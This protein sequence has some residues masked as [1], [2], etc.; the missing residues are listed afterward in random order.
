MLT[1]AIF[2]ELG[3]PKT[4]LTPLVYIYRLDTDALVVNGAAMTEVGN[5]QYKY[6]FA[7]W[8]RSIDY[9]VICDS[10][11]LTGSER[12]AYSS[13][14][15]DQ[16]QTELERITADV[17][18]EAKQDIIDTVVDG[19]QTD[20]DNPVDGLGALKLAIVNSTTGAIEDTLSSN[21][22]LIL[23]L[24]KAVG[25]AQGG[26]STNIAFRSADNTKDRIR[27]KVDTLGN[28]SNVVLDP[29]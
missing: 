7:A 6:T 3:A 14:S 11:T 10:V 15:Q 17:A 20:L 25:I 13:I 16:Y 9:S 28:R 27:L 23:L 26:G 24:S 1:L 8:D 18:T 4:G 21:D 29:T 12:Y 5:G 2:T 22:I 19:I